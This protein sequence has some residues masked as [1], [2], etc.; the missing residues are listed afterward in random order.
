NCG[1][2]PAPCS[3]TANETARRPFQGLGK[4]VDDESAG[5]SSYHALQ[6]TVERRISAGLTLSS[7]F[8]WSK[9]I[10][11][12]SSNANGTLFSGFNTVSDPFNIRLNRGLSDFDLP[13]SFTTSFVWTLPSSKS[14][15]FVLKHVLS[16]W[17][18]TRIWIWQTG[19]PFSIL[20]G[21]DNSLTGNGLD[22][23]DRVPGV[24]PTL[25]PDRPRAQV[26]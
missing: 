5:N 13:Y 22:F 16:N 8:T 20:S 21:T 11:T 6:M 4:V 14:D 25:D 24:S 17:Q 10:D 2:P 18:A 19:E 15:S 7:N 1:T 3:T 23:A 9:S 26:I 12:V